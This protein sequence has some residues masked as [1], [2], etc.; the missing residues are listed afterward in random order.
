MIP[1]IVANLLISVTEHRRLIESVGAL[2]NLV[3]AGQQAAQ[4]AAQP[5]R[6]LPVH[7]HVVVKGSV[8]EV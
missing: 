5:A 1:I 4:P 3:R 8:I 2:T 7:V 6:S